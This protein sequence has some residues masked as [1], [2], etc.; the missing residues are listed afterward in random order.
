MPEIAL[1]T[2]LISLFDL[3]NPC[4]VS[5]VRLP[6][7][8]MRNPRPRELKSLAPGH[9]GR[10]RIRTQGVWLLTNS[11]SIVKCVLACR[12]FLA[13]L[14]GVSRVR[15]LRTSKSKPPRRPWCPPGG[16]ERL[17]LTWSPSVE[18][19]RGMGLGLGAGPV[20]REA[21]PS[22]GRGYRA[23]GVVRSRGGSCCSCVSL[24]EVGGLHGVVEVL[25][26]PRGHAVGNPNPRGQRAA[27]CAVWAGP[28]SRL[29]PQNVHQGPRGGRWTVSGLEPGVGP[30]GKGGFLS[31]PVSPLA[32]RQ[33]GSASRLWPRPL[34]VSS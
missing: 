26:R 22:G 2:L 9:S 31:L 15:G 7:S 4:E 8:R 20:R 24:T 6:I 28:R 12:W 25:G 23:R 27:S 17:R 32:E 13:G 19:G 33:R 29:M 21:G 14:T 34:L 5:T 3:H 16:R 10:A 11:D 30:G 1:R 18:G